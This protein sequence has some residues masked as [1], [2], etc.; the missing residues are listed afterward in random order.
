MIFF[1][2]LH[3]PPYL[4]LRQK[5]KVNFG[6]MERSFIIMRSLQLQRKFLAQILKTS[7][8]MA[9]VQGTSAGSEEATRRTQ[10]LAKS[11]FSESSTIQLVTGLD[12][13]LSVNLSR[14]LLLLYSPLLRSI[15]SSNLDSS[16]VLFV[17]D[18]SL[19]SLVDL[20]LLLKK[21]FVKL[22]PGTKA[23]DIKDS[24][25]ILGIN[26]K[27]LSLLKTQDTNDSVSTLSVPLKQL[28]QHNPNIETKSES[29]LTALDK[30]PMSV[31]SKA[32]VDSKIG[33]HKSSLAPVVTQ[34]VKAERET[35]LETSLDEILGKEGSQ[36][37]PAAAPERES[38]RDEP[39]ASDR[40]SGREEPEFSCQ[41]QRQRCTGKDFGRL[42]TL[43]V[44]YSQHFRSR[45]KTAF[46][47]KIIE[48]EC[49][50]CKKKFADKD[51]MACHI[52]AEHKKVDKFLRE[53]GI[54][55]ENALSPE[56]T[57]TSPAKASFQR[58]ERLTTNVLCNF[59][60]KCEVC[61]KEVGSSAYM[62]VHVSGHFHQQLKERFHKFTNNLD[63]TLCGTGQGSIKALYKHIG[64][65]HLKVNEILLEKG[66]KILPSTLTNKQEEKQEHLKR[67][68]KE[69]SEDV[70]ESSDANRNEN[71]GD[72]EERAITKDEPRTYSFTDINTLYPQINTLVSC[73]KVA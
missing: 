56:N 29:S 3:F 53:M 23:Q 68:K 52:G 17:P 51:K 11:F 63:C 40:G 19:S 16:D 72:E 44:H 10:L 22:H 26:L 69:I 65:Q 8:K 28:S 48:D 59:D 18:A 43:R 36:D 35:D 14:N 67:I 24:A 64:V 32:Q 6:G 4:F 2:I 45:L 34:V 55:L 33:A 27:Q 58:K 60:T 66:F 13:R 71:K 15:F 61:G 5:G 12:Q 46:A 37:E 54:V 39:V 50:R 38:G 9:S 21:G 47:S 7:S 1:P 49:Y 62:P 73:V 70:A 31:E 42:H 41:I 20:E 30:S 57:P 25:R